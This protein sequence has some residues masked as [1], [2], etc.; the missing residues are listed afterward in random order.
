MQEQLPITTASQIWAM[1]EQ[2]PSEAAATNPAANSPMPRSPRW[3]AVVVLLLLGAVSLFVTLLVVLSSAEGTGATARAG[4]PAPEIV[5]LDLS[6]TQVKLSGWRGRPVVVNFW[7]TWCPPCK[8]EMPLLVAA[9]TR[10]QA[11]DDLVVLGLNL[12]PPMSKN[13]VKRFM[14]DQQ[15]NFPVVMDD[16]EQQYGKLYQAVT[17]PVTYFIDRDGVT[18]YIQL[19][20]MTADQLEANLKLILNRQQQ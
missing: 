5:G 8:Q 16:R 11:S 18:R 12:D 20:E 4:Q 7:A 6:G 3:R 1:V 2:S 19:G 10:Y 9:Y 14:A 13:H 15:I 17:L